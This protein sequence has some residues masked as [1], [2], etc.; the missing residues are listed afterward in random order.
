M[1]QSMNTEKER[2]IKEAF[3]K[4]VLQFQVVIKPSLKSPISNV[5]DDV[6]IDQIIPVTNYPP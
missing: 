2:A 6:R 3:K 5:T 4:Q 1:V